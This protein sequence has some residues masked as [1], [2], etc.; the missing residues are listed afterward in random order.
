MWQGLMGQNGALTSQCN[1]KPK[2]YNRSKDRFMIRFLIGVS[3]RWAFLLTMRLYY[4]VHRATTSFSAVETDAGATLRSNATA[5]LIAP[6][7]SS[8][9]GD[10]FWAV[11]HWIPRLVRG[12]VGHGY[13]HGILRLDSHVKASI[14]VK[15]EKRSECR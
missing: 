10:C 5:S 7:K 4:A 11:T 6:T 8:A 12:W 13:C 3:I 9:E 14:C 15:T 2:I 1:V